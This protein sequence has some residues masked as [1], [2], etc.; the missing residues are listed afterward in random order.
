VSV[1][2]I[3][4]CSFTA[5]FRTGTGS[6]CKTGRDKQNEDEYFSFH[7]L[8]Y[9]KLNNTNSAVKRGY[10]LDWPVTEDADDTFREDSGGRIQRND[11]L[12]IYATPAYIKKQFL[13]I[14]SVKYF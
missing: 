12:F 5:T 14:N 3:A 7:F 13:G 2:N 6:H 11:K 10:C 8:W 1:S 9:L 4:F